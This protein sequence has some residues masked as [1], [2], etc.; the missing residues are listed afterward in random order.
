[1]RGLILGAIAGAAGTM[2]LDY[3][4]YVD[5][6]V[7]GRAASSLPADVIRSLAEKAGIAALS[8]ADDQADA[9]TKNRRTALG[10]LAGYKIGIVLG[11][12]YG[13]A[14]YPS[15]EKRG[16]VFR[17][18]ALTALAMASSDVPATLLGLTNPA[19]WGTTGWISDLVPH[20]AYGLVTAAVFEAIA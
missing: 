15:T 18:I 2:A 3:T 14:S 8:V 4:S 1:M 5:M 12:L 9:S 17:S 16:I 20:A 6:A 7:G 11:A 10:A 13:L 19:E